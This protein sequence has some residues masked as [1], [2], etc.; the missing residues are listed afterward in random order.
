MVV[1]G[2]IPYNTPLHWKESAFL[3]VGDEVMRAEEGQDRIHVLNSA[4]QRIQVERF[5][6][7]AWVPVHVE[8]VPKTGRWVPKR[9]P[10]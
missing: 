5:P 2:S 3:L 6:R 1:H 4:A 7:M 9:H 10:A 8:D